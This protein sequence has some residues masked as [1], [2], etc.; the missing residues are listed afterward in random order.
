MSQPLHESSFC[1]HHELDPRVLGQPRPPP[2]VRREAHRQGYSGD[3][4]REHDLAQRHACRAARDHAAARSITKRVALAAD[5]AGVM[6]AAEV[7]APR[8]R[9]ARGAR[10]EQRALVRF[11]QLGGAAREERR[12][13]LRQRLIVGGRQRHLSPARELRHVV[14]AARLRARPHRRGLPAAEG[15]AAHDRACDVAI[16]VEGAGLDAVDPACDLAVV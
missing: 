11:R 12:D 3:A 5:R 9:V 14:R 2:R 15:L 13:R 8:A 7:P 6:L 1:L 10:R 16:H 4:R